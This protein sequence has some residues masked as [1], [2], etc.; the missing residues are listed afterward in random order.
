VAKVF[1]LAV[2][3]LGSLARSFRSTIPLDT[4]HLSRS[5]LQQLKQREDLL[6]ALDEWVLSPD[7]KL[8]PKLKELAQFLAKIY[9][10]NHKLTVYRGF[11]PDDSYQDTMGLSEKGFFSNKVHPHEVGQIFRYAS[12]DRP[13]SFSTDLEIAHAFGTTVITTTLDPAHQSFLIL[14]DELMALLSERRN[15]PAETQKEVILLPPFDIVF[16]ILQKD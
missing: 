16:S 4:T 2:E 1:R 11:D 13:L 6:E 9:G 12:K 5:H 7:A 3:G 8:L 14:T 15:I 10:L